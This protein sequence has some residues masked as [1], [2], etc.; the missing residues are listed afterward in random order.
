MGD[1]IGE[2][3]SGAASTTLEGVASIVKTF[4][5][6]PETLIMDNLLGDLA[7]GEP[8]IGDLDATGLSIKS[9]TGAKETRLLSRRVD[10]RLI[11]FA[12]AA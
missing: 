11:C 8:L 3:P 7:T 4:R 6:E 2:G 5:G 12:S 1:F 10:L 9:S